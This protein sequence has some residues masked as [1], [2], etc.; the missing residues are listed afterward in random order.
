MNPGSECFL[1]IV[2]KGHESLK[3]LLL[4]LKKISNLTYTWFKKPGTKMYR[5]SSSPPHMSYSTHM[6][7][8]TC[9]DITSVS[10]RSTKRFCSYIDSSC[11]YLQFP[12]I[13]LEF[14]LKPVMIKNGFIFNTGIWDIFKIQGKLS[15]CGML[16]GGA[17]RRQSSSAATI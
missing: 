16:G 12:S 17:G 14:L 7:C 9:T 2:S 10:S 8:C 13:W 3:Q 15:S 11:I 6:L 4:N 1:C 5:C